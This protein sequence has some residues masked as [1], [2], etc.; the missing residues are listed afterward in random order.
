MLWVVHP[1]DSESVSYLTQRTKSLM[2]LFYLLTLYAAIR[3]PPLHAVDLWTAAAVVAS[4]LGMASKESMVTAPVMVLLFDRVFLY[5]SW[6]EAWAER[7]HLYGG[8]AASWVVL[9]RP[10]VR[11][12]ARPW[13]RH[14][15]RPPGSTS[16]TSC[17]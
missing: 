4:A 2:A 1:L 15:A 5:G 6:R 8:L 10:V 11:A 13:V 9:G 14:Q 16:S 7:R 3:P 17:R 12:A